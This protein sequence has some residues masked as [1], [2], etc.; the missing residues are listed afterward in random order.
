MPAQ[1]SQQPRDSG[2]ASAGAWRL[3]DAW[4]S[5]IAEHFF[6]S[7]RFC[8]RAVYLSIDSDS[9]VEIAAS[10]GIG[11][12]DI[13]DSLSA[14]V[15]PT[16]NL[17]ASLAHVFADH[18]ERL[19]DWRKAGGTGPP[20]Q[21][22]LLAFFSRVAAS[23]AREQAFA[24]TDFYGRLATHLHVTGQDA[25]QRLR[26]DF[27]FE[28][29]EHWA[30]L[31]RWLEEHDGRYGLPTACS[32]DHRRFV[33]VP[34]S[35]V[36]L[37]AE[38]RRR[39]VGL[40]D[41]F[42]LTPGQL[43]SMADMVALLG[44]W[45]LHETGCAQLKSLWKR[46]GLRE[47]IAEI[48]CLELETWAGAPSSESASGQVEA[49]LVAAAS[50]WE[51]PWPQFALDFQVRAAS[52]G[53]HRE[54]E[55]TPDTAR[56]L[57][58]LL[59]SRL[60]RLRLRDTGHGSWLSLP[61]I[62]EAGLSN[63]LLSRVTLRSRDS[64]NVVLTRRPRPV[65]PLHF[66][67]LECRFVEV[68]RAQFG[69]TYLVLA[70]RAR[71]AMVE[72]ALVQAACGG[73]R[74]RDDLQGLPRDWI[75]FT[76]VVIVSQPASDEETLRPLSPLATIHLAARGGFVL[77]R[78]T[79]LSSQPPDL[80]A[81]APSA[82]AGVFIDGVEGRPRRIGLLAPVGE[83][84]GAGCWSVR[85]AVSSDGDYRAYISDNV[86][87]KVQDSIPIHLR[88][89]ATPRPAAV[90]KTP[91]LAHAFDAPSGVLSAEPSDEAETN[92][93]RGAQLPKSVSAPPGA[94][95][96]MAQGEQT[97]VPEGEGPEREVV[98]P[99][100]AEEAATVAPNCAV[101]GYHVWRLPPGGVGFHP[102]RQGSCACGAS[103][104]FPRLR[105][106]RH[107]TT[108]ESD[109]LEKR[110][111][112]ADSQGA[113]ARDNAGPA[114][115]TLAASG[116]GD[117]LDAV[118]Y[119]RRGEW[120]EYERLAR[121][122]SSDPWTA[123]V[124]A[125]A[126]SALGHIDLQVSRGRPSHWAVAPPTVVVS[127]RAAPFL[128]GARCR[129]LLAC[130]GATASQIG[131][132]V[133]TEPQAY[134]PD[135]VRV[136]NVAGDRLDRLVSQVSEKT[137][138]AIAL[139]ERPGERLATLL[140]TLGSVVASLPATPAPHGPWERFDP[141]SARW[142]PAEEA[143]VPGSY[144]TADYPRLYFVVTEADSRRGECRVATV[145]AVK[146]MAALLAGTRLVHYH[147][148]EEALEVPLGAE[149]PGLYERAVV[150]CS[151][152]LPDRRGGRRRYCGVSPDVAS[153]LTGLLTRGA[154]T[155]A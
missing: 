7:G 82:G 113:R 43:L 34:L 143:D 137:G 3:Y 108:L 125:H 44:D 26:E 22:A 89:A 14:A 33:S 27:G 133:V 110:R 124:S 132:R 21:L 139:S 13:D 65:V 54:L 96:V 111:P 145:Q 51:E 129:P 155:R 87:G 68:E 97:P 72:A 91:D 152:R 2:D 107:G 105:S 154:T 80:V 128:A 5:A 116:Y 112:D 62:G 64:A 73:F 78:N 85:D 71:A 40:F 1:P 38:D 92:L 103:K 58:P 76:D 70:H 60:A 134:G 31:N 69:E 120:A 11:V 47:R 45:L 90:L 123:T 118:T 127:E 135:V 101:T 59:G 52:V 148:R 126:L 141:A 42:D 106:G 16:L 17:R 37:R 66:E 53:R 23:M 30:A 74:R 67:P 50:L 102:A 48:A 75:L 131:G 12:S 130:L 36:L 77:G 144:R 122:L 32:F 136:D 153:Q 15:Q 8:G 81:V 93:L 18:K 117:L 61:D 98:R 100:R 24:A 79:W 35:Q 20:P 25:V 86:D 19:R 94:A 63:V 4:N 6:L 138:L 10:L 57:A 149:L 119:Q 99:A 151:G 115:T 150:L 114:V 104:Y 29:L 83:A 49:R 88:S 121:Q 142:Q 28:S 109:T 147:T 41:A 84:G 95:F 140:P 55:L 9:E 46:E 56:V 146:H 39:L